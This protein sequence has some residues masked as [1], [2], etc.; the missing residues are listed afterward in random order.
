MKKF[1]GIKMSD[2]F[3]KYAVYKTAIG[4]DFDLVVEFNEDNELVAIEYPISEQEELK[5]NIY[6]T[7]KKLQET[8]YIANKLAEANTRYNLTS[9]KT[10]LVELTTKYKKELDDRIVWRKEIDE[11][12]Q[13]LKQEE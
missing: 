3:Y 9:D 12:K 4:E 11:L 10:E 6:N 8:D 5:M 7:T 1:N 13:K 2:T